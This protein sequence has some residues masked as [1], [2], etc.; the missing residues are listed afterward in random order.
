MTTPTTP[1]PV[2]RY[3]QPG[4]TAVYW[5]TSLTLTLP[6][7]AQV[8]A[9]TSQVL[10][11][12]IAAVTG[13]K[14]TGQNIETPDLGKRFNTKVAGRTTAEDGMI[15]FYASATGADVRSIF[16][17]SNPPLAGYIAFF[18]NGA[19]TGSAADYYKVTVSSVGRGRDIEAVPTLDVL[20]A[21]T[22]FNEGGLYPTV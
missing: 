10:Q 9:T 7:I 3:F 2:T 16:T 22:D 20:F 8:T 13:F 12:D 1:T 5:I 6:T 18:A 17:V 15:T 4:T 14:I 19:V 21:I 11:A